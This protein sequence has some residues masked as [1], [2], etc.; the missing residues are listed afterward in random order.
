MARKIIDPQPIIH[1]LGN[2]CLKAKGLE[3]SLLGEVID[4]LRSAPNVGAGAGFVL[5]DDV[6]INTDQIRSFLWKNGE[7]C[8]WYAGQHFFVSWDDPERKLYKNL[9]ESLGV[10]PYEDPATDLENKND[11]Q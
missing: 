2:R 6:H 3:C 10:L 8:A 5:I 7:L 11:D 4:L 1:Y 9:C